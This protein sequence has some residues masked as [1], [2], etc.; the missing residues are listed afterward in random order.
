MVGVELS[1]PDTEGSATDACNVKPSYSRAL[2]LEKPQYLLTAHPGTIRESTASHVQR[3]DARRKIRGSAALCTWRA[4]S[5]LPPLRPALASAG[6][7]SRS[8]VAGRGSQRSSSGSLQTESPPGQL[9][10]RKASHAPPP[11]SCARLHKACLP[12]HT[13]TSR[14]RPDR[15]WCTRC[16]LCSW[17]CC[18]RRC[19]LTLPASGH[20]CRRWPPLL[21]GCSAPPCCSS[22]GRRLLPGAEPS[23]AFARL[24][25]AILSSSALAL[26]SPSY[27]PITPMGIG[28][29]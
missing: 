9:Q 4:S 28:I 8:G 11:L 21:P 6:G 20:R 13:L 17:G 18:G 15:R 26:S 25:S 5:S 29:I 19:L 14:A 3:L 7:S 23:A 1:T 12:R 16:S 22:S 27:T 10:C 2:P 24:R